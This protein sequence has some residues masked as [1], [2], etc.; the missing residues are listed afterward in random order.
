MK[1]IVAPADDGRGRHDGEVG[2]DAGGGLPTAAQ[3]RDLDGLWLEVS[4]WKVRSDCMEILD[5]ENCLHNG[6]FIQA[7]R[8]GLEI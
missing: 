2:K 1:R 4:V 3:G 5:V 7:F 8:L 6:C